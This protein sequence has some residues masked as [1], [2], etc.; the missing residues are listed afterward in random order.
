M[1]PVSQAASLYG[2]LRLASVWLQNETRLSATNVQRTTQRNTILT[3]AFGTEYLPATWFSIGVEA[4][5]G[6]VFLGDEQ[7]SSAAGSATGSGGSATTLQGLFFL[8][9]YFL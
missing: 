3:F 5:L 8:R 1:K 9:T 4:Q 2:G 7:I 6:F